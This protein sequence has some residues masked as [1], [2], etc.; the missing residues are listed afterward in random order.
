MVLQLMSGSVQPEQW[1]H[2]LRMA[3]RG[4]LWARDFADMVQDVL[5][6]APWLCTGSGTVTCRYN[7]MNKKSW[8]LVFF[9]AFSVED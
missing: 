3:W 9:G 5:W 1:A 2:D 8:L 6:S 7:L 4:E